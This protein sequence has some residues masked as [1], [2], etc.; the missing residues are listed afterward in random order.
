[1]IFEN[2]TEFSLYI[3]ELSLNKRMTHIDAVLYYCKENFVE[4][5]EIAPLISPSL[6]DKIAMNMRADRQGTTYTPM[7]DA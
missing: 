1:M 4:P 5:E 3:E 6:K 7:L 2:A